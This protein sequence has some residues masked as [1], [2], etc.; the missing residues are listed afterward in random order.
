MK[1]RIILADGR[2]VIA[3][4][5]K[6]FLESHDEFVVVRT[7][8]DG[9]E[10]VNAVRV[11]KPDVVLVAL[12]TA[13]QCGL[14]LIR[15]IKS[16]GLDCPTALFADA[17]GEEDTMKALRLGVDGVVLTEMPPNLLVQCLLK[18][19]RGE[20]WIEKVAMSRALD[21]MLRRQEAERKASISLTPREIDV[22][23]LVSDGLRN[24]EIASQLNIGEGT[25]KVY[26]TTIYKKL[27]VSS[28]VEL[29]AHAH[30]SDLV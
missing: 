16:E 4:A 21:R 28:R 2:L 12:G 27:D 13:R 26:L 15:K 19:S 14:E 3:A 23:R 18:V 9:A 25:V 30:K 20:Q 6:A 29:A 7:C 22:V 1:V 8:A 10:T 24:K 17:L 11:L 5:L